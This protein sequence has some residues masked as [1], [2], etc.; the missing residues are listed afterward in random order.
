MTVDGAIHP[1]GSDSAE[2]AAFA[3]ILCAVDGSPESFAA[4][5]QAAGLAGRG[6]H[7]TLLEVTSYDF[8]GANRGPAVGPLQAKRTLDRAAELARE[9]GVS[10]TVEVDPESPPAQVVLDWAAERDLLAIGAPTTSWFR[11]MFTSGVAVSA[12]GSFSTPLLIARLAREVPTADRHILV[13][14]DGQEGSDQLVE[15]AAGLA[16]AQGADV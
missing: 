1:P 9:A 16:R 8:Q 13:A 12:E 6:G 7:L 3:D 5:E 2:G 14:S 10:A 11:G 4:V 15:L